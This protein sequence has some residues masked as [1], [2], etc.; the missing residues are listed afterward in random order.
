MIDRSRR[1]EAAERKLREL[2][3]AVA[4]DHTGRLSVE[5]INRQ[6]REASG[7]YAECGAVVKA[8]LDQFAFDLLTMIEHAYRWRGRRRWRDGSAG[9]IIIW[10]GPS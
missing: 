9:S 6:F 1:P 4:A 5:I 7:S 8:W 2:A 3:N 10:P